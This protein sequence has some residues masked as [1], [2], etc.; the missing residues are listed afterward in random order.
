MLA[1]MLEQGNVEF[2]SPRQMTKGSRKKGRRATRPSFS[3]TLYELAKVPSEKFVYL[4]R[5]LGG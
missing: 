1:G 2:P 4:T 3:D 5:R